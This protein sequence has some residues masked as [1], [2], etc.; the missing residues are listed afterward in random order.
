[1]Q[2]GLGLD[3]GVEESHRAADLR[4]AEPNAQEVGLVAH[5]HRDAVSLLQPDSVEEN[6]SQPVAA[7]LHV[8]VGVGPSLVDDERLV[9]DAFRL[10]D[11]PVE[12]R[13][14]AGG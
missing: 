11:E 5:E 12:H 9:G 10:L 3:V 7:P 14:H 2:Q 8:P 1:M 13:E 4:Q 6:V